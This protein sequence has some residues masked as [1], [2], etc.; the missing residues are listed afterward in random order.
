LILSWKIGLIPQS[1]ANGLAN[2]LILL[3]LISSLHGSLLDV[4]LV[5]AFSALALIPSQIVWGRLVDSAGRCK[6]YLIFGSVG[7][8]AA[9]VA[10]PWSGT[11]STLLA[12]VAFKSV[13]LAATL[14]ARQ[15]LTVESEQHSGWRRG[16]AN[17]QFVTSMGETAG[18]GLGA[19][20][21][22][23]VGY[24]QLFLMCGALSVASAALLGILA[25]EPGIM[26]QRKLVAVERSVSTLI[27]VSNLVSS[28]LRLSQEFSKGILRKLQ[29][30]TKFLMIGI[31]GFSLAGS[32]LFSPLPAY[33]LRFYSSSDV[34]MVF[35]SGSLVGALCYP[36]IGR[37]AQSPG[38]S[39]V[40]ASLARTM[41]APMLL[42]VAAGAGQGLF[43]AIVI[44]A[45]LEAFWSLFD[46]TSMFAFLESARAGRAG[47]YGAAV[48]LGAAGGGIIGGFVSM[49]FG[50]AVLFALSSAICAGSFLAFTAQSRG[51][52]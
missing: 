23:S 10:I 52:F 22:S 12:L 7:M 17:M 6:P 27:I 43:L 38:K 37:F 44:L 20:M 1:V 28:P 24:T 35:F 40:L 48:G 11:V 31:L 50:F 25:R 8:G 4:G 5:A 30:T 29:Q 36:V 19:V 34:L 14:P 39:L 42:L 21:V 15:L 13:M 26:I 3:F 32:A 46:I 9:L 33:F 51:R 49:Q 41:V 45:V 47:F 2:I 18:I 16:L